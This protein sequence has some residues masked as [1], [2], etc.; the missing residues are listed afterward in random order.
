[1]LELAESSIV[2]LKGAFKQQGENCRGPIVARK[3]RWLFVRLVAVFSTSCQLNHAEA[4]LAV[5]G[6]RERLG[7]ATRQGIAG[8]FGAIVAL[9][10]P[11][12]T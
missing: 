6:I 10:I 8:P 1:M 4:V 12:W 7:I 2:P 3:F 5:K 11:S 9:F